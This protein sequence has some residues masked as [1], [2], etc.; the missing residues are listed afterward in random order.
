MRDTLTLL[1]LLAV[2]LL[3]A[4]FL[5]QPA[6]QLPPPSAQASQQKISNGVASASHPGRG[7]V[8]SDNE[9]T[10]ADL[11][12]LYS[13]PVASKRKARRKVIHGVP[14][15]EFVALQ[16]NRIETGNMPE[17]TDLGMKLYL[18]CL[19]LKKN[20][21]LVAPRECTRV[22]KSPSAQITRVGGPN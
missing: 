3:G 7:R 11:P 15:D 17:E 5:R 21:E 13:A 16:R 10:A 18:Q 4:R 12:D 9:E 20:P 8:T 19:E 22:F 6:T 14:V 1:G 2:I